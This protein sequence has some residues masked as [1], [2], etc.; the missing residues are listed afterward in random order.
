MYHNIFLNTKR[1]L[2]NL[3]KFLIKNKLYVQYMFMFLFLFYSN[4]KNNSIHFFN[5]ST[6]LFFAFY[7]MCLSV[8]RYIILYDMMYSAVK[9]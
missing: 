7:L 3:Y 6:V 4:F 8:G 5:I 2:R 9:Q 1:R